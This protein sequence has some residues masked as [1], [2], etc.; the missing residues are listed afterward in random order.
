MAER[1]VGEDKVFASVAPSLLLECL[2]FAWDLSKSP[3]AFGNICR[4]VFKRAAS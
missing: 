2:P 1:E 4:F 3:V